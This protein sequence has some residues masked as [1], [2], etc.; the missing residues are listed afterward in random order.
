MAGAGMVKS[1]SKLEG[2]AI[3]VMNLAEFLEVMEQAEW[4]KTYVVAHCWITSAAHPRRHLN[5]R[6]ATPGGLVRNRAAAARKR[7]GQVAKGDAMRAAACKGRQ[8]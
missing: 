1:G 8:I 3:A 2:G 6:R 5:R 7:L 4:R